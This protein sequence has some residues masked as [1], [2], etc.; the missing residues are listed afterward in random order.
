MKVNCT[1]LPPNA[2]SCGGISEADKILLGNVRFAFQQVLVPCVALFGIV[3][4][5]LTMIIMTRRRMRSSTNNYLAALATADCL[6]LI[7]T[8]LLSLQHQF[9][10]DDPKFNLYRR[11]KPLMLLLVD[12]SQNTSVWLTVTFTIERYIAV[13]HPMRGKVLCTESRSRKIILVV[14]L[15]TT[16]LTLP[17]YFEYK[18]IDDVNDRNETIAIIEDSDL[19]ADVLYQS[20]YYWLTVVMNTILPLLI[21]IVF[22][23]FLIRSV[24][25][26]RRQRK[27]MTLRQRPDSARDPSSQE[28]KITVMLIAVVVLFLLCQLPQAGLLIYTIVDDESS[29]FT[30]LLGNLFN[31]L[32]C[33]NAS[34]NFVLYCLL[35]N[36]YRRTFFNMFF[37]CCQAN[38]NPLLHSVYGQ[39]HNSTTDDSPGANRRLSS[40]RLARSSSGG[41][42][43]DGASNH[44]LSV[45]G[46]PPALS[47][48]N[49]SGQQNQQQQQQNQNQNQ[50]QQQHRNGRP[51]NRGVSLPESSFWSRIRLGSRLKNRSSKSVRDQK[52][53]SGQSGNNK[54]CVVIVT[55]AP[56]DETRKENPEV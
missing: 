52:R 7:C 24:H 27:T 55:D 56:S 8:I 53:N 40:C 50:Q 25:I 6:Y 35:S 44:L 33:V 5:S 2:T 13:C 14:L 54:E 47:N 23:S 34:G 12:T 17:T 32:V 49:V 9:A 11:F 22:N 45:P 31:F 16:V 18:I 3:F 37:P 36:K 48:N 26:S 39:Y 19:G 41:T 30:R 28:N 29:T 21:L 15:Y 46:R 51:M 4:N 10:E 38:I 1:G 20:V 42:G 43:T